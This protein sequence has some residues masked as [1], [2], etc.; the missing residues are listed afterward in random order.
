[1]RS[2][3]A[4]TIF[5]EALMQNWYRFDGRPRSFNM[6]RVGSGWVEMRERRAELLRGV[7]ER[8]A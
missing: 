4:K 7:G 6:T 1:M 5:E 2:K 3:L 8:A